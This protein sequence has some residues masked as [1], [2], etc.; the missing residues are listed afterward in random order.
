M[1]RYLVPVFF[2]LTA[3]NCASSPKRLRDLGVSYTVD[4]P[5]VGDLYICTLVE[6]DTPHG[7]LLCLTPPEAMDV[8]GEAEVERDAQINKQAL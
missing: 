3:C 5:V 4:E 2:I 7:R 1:Y 6:T 8:L